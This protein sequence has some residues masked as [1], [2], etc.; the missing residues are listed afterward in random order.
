M[1]NNIL[2]IAL[3][4]LVGLLSGILLLVGIG[5]A[6][7]VAV[8][9]ISA[10]LAEISSSV[11]ALQQKLDSGA[12]QGSLSAQLAALDKKLE[13]LN[14]GAA[15]RQAQPP[16]PPSEDFNKVYTIPVGTTPVAGLKSA[17]I[18]IVE[19]SDLQCPFCARFYPAV[20]EVMKAYPDK[21]NMMVKNFPLPFHPNARPAAKLALA[22]NLQG[23]YFEMVELL[24]SN[25]G[26]VSDA[27][28]KEYADALKLDLKKLTAD[29][30][31]KDA[32]WEKIIEADLQLGSEVDVRGTPT[33][34]INGKKTMARDLNGY[35]AEIE[36]ILA[37]KR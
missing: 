14:N 26:D 2:I 30:K 16:Q 36:K 4:V 8:S 34:Y 23:K 17:P 7:N 22:A 11:K 13:G 9:P 18:T 28:I 10:Q 35:K 12:G 33:F 1:K 3:V 5:Q 25:G 21:I 15:P 6:V 20:K 37:E 31:D 19:F 27:K 29:Y 32:E 24:L